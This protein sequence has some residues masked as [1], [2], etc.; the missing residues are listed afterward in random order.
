MAPAYAGK[1]EKIR[2]NGVLRVAMQ[3]RDESPFVL[4]TGKKH[5]TGIDVRIGKRIAKHL[6]VD[7]KFIRTVKTPDQVVR[8]VERGEADIAIS[9]LSITLD[10]AL[11]VGFSSPYIHLHK[12][13][14][15]SQKHF[16]LLKKNDN[17][18]LRTFFSGKNKLGVMK[19]SSYVEFARVEF[20]NAELVE[21]DDWDQLVQDLNEGKVAGGFWDQFEIE[22]VVL[23]EPHGLLNY[24]VVQLQV[25]T[26][27]VAIA[28]PKNDVHFLRW[29]NTFMEIEVNI[30]SARDLA[31]SYMKYGRENESR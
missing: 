20:P 16:N 24:F 6:G 27:K 1:I 7:V 12:A 31:I 25:P 2:A 13:V 9:N 19:E 29:I 8:Q 17:E 4:K 23:T 5:L 11:R 18:T 10:R 3:M 22:K 28:L 30:L 26:D 21:Y 15:L 14:I